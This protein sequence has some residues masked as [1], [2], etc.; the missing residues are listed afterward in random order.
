MSVLGTR[1]YLAIAVLAPLIVGGLPADRTYSFMGSV[2]PRGYAHYCGATLVSPQWM[3]TAAHCVQGKNPATTRIRIGSSDRTT[4][5]ELAQAARF[6][7]HPAY[8]GDDYDIALIQLAAPSAMTPAPIATDSPS[9]STAVRLLGWGQTCPWWRCAGR[10]PIGLRQLDTTV[11]DDSGCQEFNSANELCLAGTTAATAC[12]GDSGGPALVREGEKW[13][14]AGLTSRGGD[15]SYTCGTGNAIYTDVVAFAS[16]IR[17][18]SF[19]A[20][21]PG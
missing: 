19:G 14:V 5:G 4:G 12:Y 15:D 7:V 10:G 2:Q 8:A 11:T 17:L 18:M 13:A 9:P 1:Q 16:W 3:V 20:S 21:D 6:V